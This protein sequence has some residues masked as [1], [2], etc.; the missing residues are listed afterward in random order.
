PWSDEA[1][2][3]A[4]RQIF[5]TLVEVDPATSKVTPALASSW[6]TANDGATWTFTLREGVRFHDGSALDAAAV[7]A[8]FDRGRTTRAYRALFG[9]A[10]AV[11]SIQVV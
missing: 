8:S 6:Q 9:D 4:I 5:E 3:V 7:A 11:Q 2:L 1:S 10:S